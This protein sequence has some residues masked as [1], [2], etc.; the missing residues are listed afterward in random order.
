MSNEFQSG[1]RSS[2]RAKRKKTNIILNSLIVLVLAL[3]VFV[4][5]SIFSSGDENLS[6][7]KNQPKTEETKTSDEEKQEKDEKQQAEEEK[8]VESESGEEGVEVSAPESA[9][10]SQAVVTEGDGSSNVV[11][12][13]ENPSWK[14]V[15]TSQSGDHVPAY[16]LE[17]IDWQEMLTAISYATGIDKNSMQVYWLGS[18]K[19]QSNASIGT[20][21]SNDKSH[22][23]RV[24]IKWVDG[25]G[26][27][28]TR[29]EELAELQK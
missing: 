28:P 19:T 22:I 24:Y 6:T 23:Y 11:K 27:M 3:I 2:Y 15:G 1:P 18:D 21:Y 25:A 16:D 29:V 20:V 14:P 7:E 5:Y 17:S 9:D 12:T 4:A 10:E 8:A 13:I 26:W